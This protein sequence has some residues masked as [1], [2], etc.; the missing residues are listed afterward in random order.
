[1]IHKFILSYIVPQDKYI[2]KIEFCI[3]SHAK[4]AR[5]YTNTFWPSSGQGLGRK[6]KGI[7][8]AAG[9]NQPDDNEV[10]RISAR[11]PADFMARHVVLQEKN[12]SAGGTG[13]SA[14][15]TGGST[16]GSDGF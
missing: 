13:G 10:R 5:I 12:Y 2:K 15:G 6:V 16:G 7:K 9:R 1:M 14:G 8:S 11:T 3:V 4:R